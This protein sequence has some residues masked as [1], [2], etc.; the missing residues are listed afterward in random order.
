MA[1]GV[2]SFNF[3]KIR[4]QITFV[5]P[6]SFDCVCPVCWNTLIQPFTTTCC[7]KHFCKPCSVAFVK[8]DSTLCPLCNATP[9]NVGINTHFRRRL[10]Q[11][12]VYCLY[13]ENGCNW[14]GGYGRIENHLN[15][16]KEEGECQFVPVKCPLSQ[17]CECTILRKNLSAHCRNGCKYRQFTCKYCGFISTY[18][19]VTTR[20]NNEC[21]NYPLLCPNRCSTTTYPRCQLKDH[22]AQCPDENIPCTFSKMGCKEIVKRRELQKHLE[23]NDILHQTMMCK[24]V[25]EQTKKLNLQSTAIQSLGRDNRDLQ[26]RVSQI[27][28]KHRILQNT[29]QTLDDDKKKLEKNVCELTQNIFALKNPSSDDNRWVENMKVAVSKMKLNDWSLYLSKMVEITT[30]EAIVPVIFKVSLTVTKNYCQNHQRLGDCRSKHYSSSVYRSLPFYSH[31]Q[32]YKLCMLAKVV[33][34]CPCCL[35]EL[36][37]P[38]YYED[39][40]FLTSPEYTRYTYAC[41]KIPDKDFIS[42]SV[43]L[44]AEGGEYDKKIKWPFDNSVTVTL[45]NEK[46]NDGHLSIRNDYIGRNTSSQLSVKLLSGKK[47]QQTEIVKF[48]DTRCSKKHKKHSLVHRLRYIPSSSYCEADPKISDEERL[49][50][51]QEIYI[52]AYPD[53][54][55]FS[56]DAGHIAYIDK[57]PPRHLVELMVDNYIG[58]CDSHFY[59][60][61]TM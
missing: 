49:Q 43:E 5:E 37:K 34:H 11:L 10:N 19:E 52:S 13:Q 33:C 31:A 38:S 58:Q 26:G 61:I 18:K 15:F 8:K 28:Q 36:P 54:I 27:I 39:F 42:L 51:A 44:I 24:I 45:L 6:P 29:L 48:L 55:L 60:E 41:D 3:L 25:V 17:Y 46:K 22:I 4:D 30:I 9:L 23:S 53:C 47:P 21:I 1:Q 59:F 57:K 2:P 14:I 7:G 12:K 50:I 56:L 32:G 40:H 16:G 20:H 35:K